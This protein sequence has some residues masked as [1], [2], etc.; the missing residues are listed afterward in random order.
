MK[1]PRFSS[2]RKVVCLE[3]KFLGRGIISLIKSFVFLSLLNILPH[4]HPFPIYLLT[5]MHNTWFARIYDF[6]GT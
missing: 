2:H 1:V 5:L 4:I 6:G 3:K